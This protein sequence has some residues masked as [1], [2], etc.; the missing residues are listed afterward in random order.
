MA[1]KRVA[2]V[3]GNGAYANVPQLDNPVRDANAVANALRI[4]GF[5]SVAVEN[6][7]GRDALLASL[8]RFEAAADDADWALVYYAGHGIEVGGTNY[9]VPVDA[10]LRRIATLKMKRSL[11][12]KCRSVSRARSDCGSSSLMRA[13]T[14]PLLRA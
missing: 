10:K 3:I 8:R 6:N 1:D 11:C 14:I 12:H 4:A 13:A 7:L 9:L 2:L 5:A